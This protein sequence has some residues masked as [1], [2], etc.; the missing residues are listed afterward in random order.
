MEWY[1]LNYWNVRVYISIMKIY[2]T[3]VNMIFKN[4][5]IKWVNCVAFSLNFGRFCEEQTQ[6]EPHEVAIVIKNKK[7]SFEYIPRIIF[8]AEWS[9]I[10]LH[11]S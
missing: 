6:S 3:G 7:S 10:E 11:K 4:P 8:Q 9:I 5:L 2:H 1:F